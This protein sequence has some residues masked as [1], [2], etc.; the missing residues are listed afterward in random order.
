[1]L[2][3]VGSDTRRERILGAETSTVRRSPRRHIGSSFEHWRLV[4]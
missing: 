2:M 1:M 4:L 3:N